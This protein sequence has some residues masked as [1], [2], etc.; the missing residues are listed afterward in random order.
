MKFFL[1][2]LVFLIPIATANTEIP[3]ALLID[4]V[5][6]ELEGDHKLCVST[7]NLV[8]LNNE[9]SRFNSSD[10]SI[11]KYFLE[12][13][14]IF[15]RKIEEKIESSGF[16]FSEEKTVLEYSDKLLIEP[17][18][19]LGYENRHE[20]FMDT[21]NFLY[22]CASG[23]ME[24]DEILDIQYIKSS[25]SKY[26]NRPPSVKIFFKSKF[27]TPS[28]DFKELYENYSPTKLGDSKNIEFNIT[29]EGLIKVPDFYE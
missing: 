10:A 9:N 12:N 11:L 19:D 6:K 4:A 5:N 27:N 8:K 25:K 23:S 14:L 21:E 1:G 15:V 22:F 3:K 2:I 16:S 24:V 20:N 28:T 29:K 18:S 13:N 17:Y 26:V 7:I